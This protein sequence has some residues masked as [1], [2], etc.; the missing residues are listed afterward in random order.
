LNTPDLQQAFSEL[1]SWCRQHD[2]RG[3]DP[4]DALNS[5][6]FQGTPLKNSR[7]MRLALTQLVKRSPVNLRPLLLVPQQRNAKGLA[8]FALA[9]LAQHRVH[10]TGESGATAKALLHDLKEMRTETKNGIAWGY[11]FDWQS[12]VLFAPRGTPTIVPTAFAAR[13]FIEAHDAFGADEYLDIARAV[14]DF[15]VKDLPRTVETDGELCFSYA[16]KTDTRVYNASLLAA[17]CLASV[18]S[19]T[20]EPE[21]MDLAI[22]VA[23]YVVNQQKQDGSWA[24]GAESTQGWVD[25]FHT[26]FVLS[27]LF[28]VMRASKEAETE[29]EMSL[30]RGYEFWR[31]AFFLADGLPKYYDDEPF[32]VDTHAAGSALATLA[33]LSE[34][35]EDAL[36]LAEKIAN[37]SLANLRHPNG[38][39]YYQ[40]RR[41]YVVRTPFMRWSE[42]W[43]LYGLG[44]LI[45]VKGRK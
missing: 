25:N 41:F 27:S 5:K 42:A 34:K 44:R 17:E 38:S 6:L 29:F 18:A 13:A 37:W 35:V 32:P 39:F 23:R 11:N 16:P 43:M 33:D 19:K 10:K 4:F 3:Y 9:A 12:R 15:I 7:T 30:R 1:L 45:E 2:F 24:Y 22:R 28:R 26:A 31:S 21:L 8:L 20:S 36:P 14:C 40:R